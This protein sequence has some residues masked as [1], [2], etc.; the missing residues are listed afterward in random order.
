MSSSRQTQNGQASSDHLKAKQPGV[1][2]RDGPLDPAPL[3]PGE[4]RATLDPLQGS[5]A[6]ESSLPVTPPL[7]IPSAFEEGVKQIGNLRDGLI[8]I[9]IVVYGMGAAVWSYQGRRFN[10]GSLPVLDLQYFVAGIIPALII[11]SV[12]LVT[13]LTGSALKKLWKVFG[14]EASPVR[15]FIQKGI[16]VLYVLDAV[17]FVLLWIFGRHLKISQIV[18]T[19]MLYAGLAVLMA[20]SPLF[21]RVWKKGSA[22]EFRLVGSDWRTIGTYPVLVGGL[23]LYLYAG[24]VYPQLSQ[25]FGGALPRIAYL[26]LKSSDLSPED[27]ADLFPVAPAKPPI[28]IR[29]TILVDVF[30]SNKEMLVVKPHVKWLDNRTYQLDASSVKAITWIDPAALKLR[31][32]RRT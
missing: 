7:P 16:S 23:C 30:F 6:P 28:S 5:V 8:V 14:P 22:Q 21:A 3:S 2:K 26:D 24:F 27:Q 11:L 25:S 19:A 12:F 13:Y 32:A 1:E 29:R 20:G 18:V 31:E 17:A 4:A 15:R 9:S 10:L